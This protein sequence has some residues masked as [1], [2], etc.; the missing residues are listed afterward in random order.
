VSIASRRSAVVVVDGWGNERVRPG[1]S[2]FNGRRDEENHLRIE[3][4]C[5]VRFTEFV[6]GEMIPEELLEF[7]AHVQDCNDCR[8]YVESLSWLLAR[9]ERLLARMGREINRARGF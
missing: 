8:E 1:L 9:R 5:L 3:T 4:H 6:Q 2:I 7:G